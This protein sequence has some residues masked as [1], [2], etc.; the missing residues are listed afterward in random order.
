[1]D[2]SSGGR[3]K[4]GSSPCTVAPLEPFAMVALRSRGWRL[5]AED[6]LL[7]VMHVANTTLHRRHDHETSIEK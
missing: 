4:G 1:M 5:E 3:G 2:I 6:E 7:V